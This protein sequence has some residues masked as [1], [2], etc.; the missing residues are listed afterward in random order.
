LKHGSLLNGN[1]A[2]KGSTLKGNQQ[3]ALKLARLPDR[4][5]VKLAI[6][7]TPDLNA[8]LIAY[9]TLYA[10]TYGMTAE[11]VDLIPAML[12]GF[13]ESDREFVKG[14]NKLKNAADCQGD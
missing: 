1:Y 4:T 2:P 10:E 9:A 11:I 5:P 8:A 3:A 7:I 12:A 13:L 14:R 6:V